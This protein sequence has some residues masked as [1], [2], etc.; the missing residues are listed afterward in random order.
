MFYALCFSILLLFLLLFII[1][2]EPGAIVE[3]MEDNSSLTSSSQCSSYQ[4]YDDNNPMMLAQKNAANIQF[5]EQRIKDL[6]DIQNQVESNKKA[7]TQMAQLASKHLTQ[8]SG[9]TPA[10]TTPASLKKVSS[11][12]SSAGNIVSPLT[13]PITDITPAKP[14]PL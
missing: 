4:K 2:K 13:A 9:I 14:L 11:I 7:I 3:P 6:H 10:M 12:G 8:S 1:K 5:L